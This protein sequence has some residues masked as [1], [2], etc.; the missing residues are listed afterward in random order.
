[1]LAFVLGARHGLDADHL[2]AIDGLTRWNASAGR[3]GAPLC[4]VIFSTGHAAV[5]V[6]AALGFA[7]LASQVTPPAWLAPVGTGISATTLI[8]LGLINLQAAF[9]PT[10]AGAPV[11]HAG[12]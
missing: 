3:R 2:A 10:G 6:A 11:V 4:G 9:S 7:V 1:M 12:P 5:I 8:A